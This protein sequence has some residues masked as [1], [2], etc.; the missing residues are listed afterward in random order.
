MKNIYETLE[1]CKDVYNLSPAQAPEISYIAV[2]EV[3]EELTGKIEKLE[4]NSEK[5]ES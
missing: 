2:I 3:I 4:Q 1:K 5:S